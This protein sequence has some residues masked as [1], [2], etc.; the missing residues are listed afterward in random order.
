MLARSVFSCNPQLVRRGDGQTARV[1]DI[2][3]EETNAKDET[4]GGGKH[5]RGGVAL[6]ESEL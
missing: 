6:L 2:Q 3:R 4:G 5:Q 1:R